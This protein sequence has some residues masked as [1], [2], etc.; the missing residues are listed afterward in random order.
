[1]IHFRQVTKKFP[2]DSVALEDVTFSIEPG[3]MV[4]VTGPS[5][6]GKTTL[7]RLMIK[8]F[9]P[10]SGEI[11]VGEYDLANLDPKEI[12]DLR[13]QIGFVFQD[14]KLFPD[15]TAAENIALILEIMDKTMDETYAKVKELLELTGLTG[16]GNLFPSQLSG[17][18]IQRT[19]IARALASEPAVLFADEP[20]GN[21]DEETAV[22][23][24]QL[25]KDINDLGTTIIIATHDKD[26]MKA[27]KGRHIRLEK[28]KIVE[29]TGPQKKVNK[30]KKPKEEEKEEESKEEKKEEKEEK[31]E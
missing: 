5:G 15:R 6:A 17:G 9:S 2:P 23:I 11:Q 4:F 3:E 13:Q 29:D 18:E 19:V 16:K 10:T 26:L 12:P 14:F 21:L 25:L 31:D 20:T 28:G 22:Q 1:M 8:E 24:T 27:F 7:G 30:K